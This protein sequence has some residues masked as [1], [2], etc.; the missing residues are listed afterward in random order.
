[1]PFKH[2]TFN[3]DAKPQHV[4]QPQ[5]QKPAD[6]SNNDDLPHPKTKPLESPGNYPTLQ[7]A[8]PLAMPNDKDW[9]SGGQQDMFDEV[10]KYGSLA[11]D[12]FVAY[13]QPIFVFIPPFAEIRGGTSVVLDAS[14]NA[15]FDATKAEWEG[16]YRPTFD[17]AG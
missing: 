9:L 10:L 4:Q 16:L 3:H 13:E 11:V 15:S 6:A 14:I 17:I 8:L 1:M 2:D 12:A 7:E 5:P